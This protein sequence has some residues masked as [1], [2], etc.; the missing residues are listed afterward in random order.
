M[1]RINFRK[2]VAQLERLHGAAPNARQPLH[3]KLAV[4]RGEESGPATGKENLSDTSRDDSVC[5]CSNRRL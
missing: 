3:Y 2:I 5:D 4:H 1:H